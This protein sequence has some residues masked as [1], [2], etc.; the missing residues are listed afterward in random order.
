VN[1]VLE[2]EARPAP[3]LRLRRA[4]WKLYCAQAARRYVCPVT[5]ASLPQLSGLRGGG[6]QRGFHRWLSGYLTMAENT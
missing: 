5:A 2:L 6:S 1:N 4:P 3:P